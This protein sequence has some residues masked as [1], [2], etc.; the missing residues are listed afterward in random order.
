MTFQDGA[1]D[2][3]LW[4]VFG[5]AAA[6]VHPYEAILVA[7]ANIARVAQLRPTMQLIVAGSS[8]DSL[9]SVLQVDWQ[10][11]TDAAFS[12]V[13]WSLNESNI[14]NGPRTVVLPSPL[15]MNI[16]YWWRA[17]VGNMSGTWGNWADAWTFVVDGNAGRGYAYEYANIGIDPTQFNRRAFEAVMANISAIGPMAPWQLAHAY[18]NVGPLDRKTGTG[19]HHLYHGDVSTNTP[20]PNI[21][22]LR[23]N[24]GRSGDAIQIVCFG[25]GDL[26]STFNGIVEIYK[27]VALGWQAVP[28]NT[29]QVYPPTVNAY[30]DDRVLSRD[31]FIIDMQHQIIE[32][33]VPAGAVPPGHS[34]RIR[35]NGP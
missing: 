19:F 30:T 15:T 16:T 4:P 9:N 22:F 26:Q 17:R 11:A 35:T 21:W 28:V 27:G 5:Q 20:T 1:G 2:S 8:T 34:L 7:P 6:A 3:T 29:W 12:N 10:V 18:Q 14:Q 13:V 31:A 25:A 32:I 23:P 33:T 24:A